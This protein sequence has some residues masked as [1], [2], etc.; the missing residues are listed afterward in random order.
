MDNYDWDFLQGKLY[1]DLYELVKNYELN[2]KW[3]KEEWT[4]KANL[5][6][7]SIKAACRDLVLV[8]LIF[9]K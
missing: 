5:N 7:K 3:T 6:N 4:T 9:C 2:K 1:Q 8:S